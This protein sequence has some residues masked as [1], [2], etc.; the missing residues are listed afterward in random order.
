MG[1]IPGGKWDIVTEFKGKS[2]E[3]GGID[4]EIGGG[5]INYTSKEPNLK[6]KKGGFWNALKDVGLGIVDTQLSTIGNV[7]GIKSMQD[8]IDEDQYSNDK[9]DEAGNFVGKLA[10]TA[11]KVIPVTA[12]IASAVGTAGGMVNQVAGID[13]R[14]YDPSKHTSKLS[15]AGDIISAVGSVVGMAV[16][17]ATSASASKALAA[18]DKLT[19]AQQMSV[20]MSGI[21]KTLGQASKGMGMFG[22]GRGMQQQPQQ[23]LQ[24]TQSNPAMF[25]QQTIATP[26]QQQQYGIPAQQ[27]YSNSRSGVVTINGVNYA[28]DQYGNLVPVN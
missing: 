8:I 27:T 5:K 14:Y 10:G 16:G 18:G 4:I 9:F 19:A 7:A 28:P 13:E 6:A 23:F 1:F 15:Q 17:G 25:P 3:N 26:Y 20:N 12:P 24:Q 2:H 11:L 22:G 21:N